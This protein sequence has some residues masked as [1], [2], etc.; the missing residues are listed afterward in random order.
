MRLSRKQLM[1]L[2]I[3]I[4]VER[5][6]IFILS[7]IIFSNFYPLVRHFQAEIGFC[8][9]FSNFLETLIEDDT[10]SKD[11]L[12]LMLPAGNCQSPHHTC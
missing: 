1:V 6:L 10:S 8:R 2:A 3:N 9:P 7:E 4:C 11:N 12:E 5:K